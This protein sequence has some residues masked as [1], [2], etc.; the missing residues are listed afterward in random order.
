MR[1]CFWTTLLKKLHIRVPASGHL[2]RVK[3][4]TALCLV[5]LYAGAVAAPIA[6]AQPAQAQTVGGYFTLTGSLLYKRFGQTATVL[7][8]GK[9]LITGGDYFADNATAELYDPATGKF[10]ATGKMLDAQNSYTATLLDNGK[11]LFVQTSNMGGPTRAELYDPATRKF[12]AIAPMENARQ[13]HSATRLRNGQVLLVGGFLVTAA[14][15][16]YVPAR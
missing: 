1:R 8:N 15:E 13:G 2:T 6:Q 11:V 9:V 4:A 16:L 10:S 14:P 5:G 12:T 7:P 3:L